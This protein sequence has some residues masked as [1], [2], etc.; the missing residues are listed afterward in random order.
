M[1]EIILWIL[2]FLFPTALYFGLG[3]CMLVTIDPYDETNW[4]QKAIV[5]LFWPILALMGAF[6]EFMDLIKKLVKRRK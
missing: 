2:V 1:I 5:F 4:F 3:L 6:L